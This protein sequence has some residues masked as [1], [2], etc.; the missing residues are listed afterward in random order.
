MKLRRDVALTLFL[1]LRHLLIIRLRLTLRVHML[2][3]LS[4]IRL[5]QSGDILL[6][7]LMALSISFDMSS[8]D[9]SP[10]SPKKIKKPYSDEEFKTSGSC[11]TCDDSPVKF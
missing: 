6:Y 4:L 5:E 9:L 11:S 2:R 8:I 1:L 3:L 7:P 10:I